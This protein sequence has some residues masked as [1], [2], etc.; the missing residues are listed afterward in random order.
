M[1]PYPPRSAWTDEGA[2]RGDARRRR[3]WRRAAEGRNARGRTPGPAPDGAPPPAR[4][5]GD[6]ERGVK[7]RSRSTSRSGARRPARSPRPSR[8]PSPPPDAAGG[9]GAAAPP[10]SP[11]MSS[12]T[13]A[14]NRPCAA[15]NRAA[16]GVLL[17]VDE[18]SERANPALGAD[19]TQT[20]RPVAVVRDVGVD[21]PRGAEYADHHLVAA[22][23]R[24][25]CR[26]VVRGER[27]PR[28][29]A[30]DHPR[31]ERPPD[32]TLR[33]VRLRRNHA[34][35][36]S[37][38]PSDGPTR[39]R[40]PQ[41]RTTRLEQSAAE[42]A[43]FSR[44]EEE[45]EPGASPLLSTSPAFP[46]DVSL[47]NTSAGPPASTL[48]R[49]S[50]NVAG[51]S[52]LSLATIVTTQSLPAMA[53]SMPPGRSLSLTSSTAHRPG[54]AAALAVTEAAPGKT[55]AR[56]PA[57]PPPLRA[58]EKILSSYDPASVALNRA[59]VAQCAEG[60]RR[61]RRR[62]GPRPPRP[63]RGPRRRRRRRGPRRP[64][65]S[66]PPPPPPGGLAVVPEPVAATNRHLQNLAR[67]PGLGPRVGAL[68]DA[69]LGV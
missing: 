49:S 13:L 29:L 17:A 28:R 15:L 48:S 68:D 23:H 16:A 69:G 65:P 4:R 47:T 51:L 58:V 54:S 50:A 53:T 46:R 5:H 9:V 32:A 67:A 60:R 11:P 44:S 6:E 34:C 20:V 63:S 38:E 56:H 57:P 59:T 62:R 41:S 21:G 24:T 37:R 25:R 12:V 36:G 39:D 52:Y 42:G 26:A 64:P 61:R 27:T 14:P 43:R 35:R 2:V 8:I 40:D 3:G 10:T 22:L 33:R 66:P 19:E 30:T 18:R 31:D 55:V 1:E 7:R 45:E